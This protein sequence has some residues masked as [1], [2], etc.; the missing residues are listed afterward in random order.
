METKLNAVEIDSEGNTI[1]NLAASVANAN[2]IATSREHSDDRKKL[3][4]I[5]ML[6][7]MEK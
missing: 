2:W 3:D 6:Y 4:T 1:L 5:P 7:E